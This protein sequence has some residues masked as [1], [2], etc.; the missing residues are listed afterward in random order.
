MDGNEKRKEEKR[1]WN[2]M[3]RLK[4]G[5]SDAI[6]IKIP[7]MKE[8]EGMNMAIINKGEALTRQELNEVTGGYIVRKYSGFNMFEVIHDETGEEMGT[9]NDRESAEEYARWKGMSTRQISWGDVNA[10]RE[11]K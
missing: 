2:R 8:K 3:I 1:K 7:R 5:V 11:K 4:I 9:F 6:L 10:L